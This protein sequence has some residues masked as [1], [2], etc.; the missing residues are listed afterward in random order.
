MKLGNQYRG[1]HDEELRFLNDTESKKRSEER[2]IAK[3]ESDEVK[4]FHQY[5]HPHSVYAR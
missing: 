1:L 2:R 3:A 4:A 5:V